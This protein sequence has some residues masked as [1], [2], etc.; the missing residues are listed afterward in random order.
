[1]PSEPSLNILYEALGTPRGIVIETNNPERLR[2]R[3]YKLRDAAGDT[4]L[5]D[6]SFVSSPSVPQSH[7]WI[8]KR[9]ST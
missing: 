9:K 5:R 2:Q 7:V 8:V 6:L 3:L 4:A 1:M